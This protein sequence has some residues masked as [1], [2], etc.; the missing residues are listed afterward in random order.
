[1]QRREQILAV[2]LAG[3][4]GVFYV[5][6]KVWS[7]FNGPVE[8]LR[9]QLEVEAGRRAKKDLDLTQTLAKQR[10]LKDWK[11]RS[12]SPKPQEAALQYQQW[13]TD[14]A[15][16]VAEFS[17][18]HVT[19]EPA[20]AAA[21][22]PYVAV[23]FRLKAEATLAQVRMF[24]F[25]FYQADLLHSVSLL[26]LESPGTSGNPK[27]TV[28]L[29]FEALSLRDAPPRGPT[30]FARA[31]IA[32]DWKDPKQPLRV[33]S[34]DGFPEKGPFLVHVGSHYFEVR[35]V[36]GVNWTLAADPNSPHATSGKSVEL[37]EGE[38][39]ELV[40]VH[41]GFAKKTLADFDA[42]LRRNPFIKPVPYAPKLEFVGGRSVSRG[43]TLELICKATGFDVVAGEPV[44]AFA[45]DTP[46][47]MTLDSRTGK[48]SWKP[49][50]EQELGDVAV[51]VTVTAPALKEP[52]Q[53]TLKLA[54]KQINNPPK[55]EAIGERHAVLG[56]EMVLPV[57]A[58]DDDA[59]SKLTF[60]LANGAPEGA[61]IDPATGEFR[62]TPPNTSVP[63]PVK[64]TV[65]VADS[66]NPPMSSSQEFTINVGDDLA[67]FTV[68][69][70]IIVK[71]GKKEFWLSD[72]STNKR[73]VLHEGEVLKYADVEAT[74]IRI[75]AKSV[76]LKRTD[77]TWRLDLGEN[78]KNLRKIE[79]AS[80]APVPPPTKTPE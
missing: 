56:R 15:E 38:T 11:S 65:Q 80:A 34:T 62:W 26:G 27:L 18:V 47:G 44:F 31:E 41:P 54:V 51:K 25:R 59:D 75:D 66:G 43:G 5:V 12:L 36:S 42:I 61:K 22:Q 77:G 40:Q 20:A 48:L 60:S 39:V 58:S 64:V 30:V 13:L 28:N 49:N 57:K 23:R 71:E 2:A 17:N 78:L 6:P 24:L 68:L 33:V 55:F 69:T 76:L 21:N 79:T 63:G 32:E 52:I 16:I 10:Q 67:Q 4:L 46:Q 53:E 70:G 9:S 74:V 7:W 45:S 14:L 3:A 72:K 8:E 35:E 73:L 1:M 29:Q 50:D 19:P 37:Q